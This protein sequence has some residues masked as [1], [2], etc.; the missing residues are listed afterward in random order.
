MIPPSA[1]DASAPPS[2]LWGLILSFEDFV[3]L[4][5]APRDGNH[6]GPPHRERMQ[7]GRQK[8]TAGPCGDSVLGVSNQRRDNHLSTTALTSTTVAIGPAPKLVIGGVGQSNQLIATPD[9]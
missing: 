8:G 9:R 4:F 7:V 1:R 2:L 5:G 3:L 6:P